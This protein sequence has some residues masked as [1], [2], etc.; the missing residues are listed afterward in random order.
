MSRGFAKNFFSCKSEKN[1]RNKD[2]FYESFCCK[3]EHNSSHNPGKSRRKNYSRRLSSRV[4]SKMNKFISPA[5]E[6][7]AEYP[8]PE[9]RAEATEPD[10]A[11]GHKQDTFKDMSKG[12]PG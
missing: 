11:G 4:L 8:H 12:I 2:V 1:V 9:A 3:S 10:Q 7:E 5:T 6:G